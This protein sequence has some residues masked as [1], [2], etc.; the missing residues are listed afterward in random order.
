M[1]IIIGWRGQVGVKDE[2]QHVKQGR[3]MAPLLDATELPWA[4]LPKDPAEAEQCVKQAVATRRSV[5][6]PTC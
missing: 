6:A 2:P 5:P 4:V 3:V 1:L